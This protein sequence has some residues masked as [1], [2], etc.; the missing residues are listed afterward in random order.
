M[1]RISLI[2]ALVLY[3]VLVRAR[4][5]E[6]RG[7]TSQPPSPDDVA[8]YG[9]VTNVPVITN[10]FVFIGNEY[11]DAPYEVTQ[12]GLGIFINGHQIDRVWVL[13]PPPRVEKEPM[14]PQGI[15]TNTLFMSDT[16][17]DYVHQVADYCVQHY[18]AEQSIEKT[19]ELYRR[20]PCVSRVDYDSGSRKMIVY[21]FSGETN[22]RVMLPSARG[23]LRERNDVVRSLD[24]TRS[25][26]ETALRE[27]RAIFLVKQGS[28][29]QELPASVVRRRLPAILLL[30]NRN[31]RSAPAHERASK[32]S[33]ALA[34]AGLRLNP[35][36]LPD[37]LTNFTASSQLEQ[38]IELMLKT[39]EQR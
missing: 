2:A 32:Q 6:A 34:H 37:L 11:V 38:R 26:Y 35:G 29:R 3:G 30:R 4:C 31:I 13:P 25:Y 18:D 33:E 7:N 12:K 24:R 17:L 19:V 8:A 14:L 1:K 36:L 10:G 39:S 22:T 20:L 23:A 16:V 5:E 27:G 28:S 9:V 21:S 15:T